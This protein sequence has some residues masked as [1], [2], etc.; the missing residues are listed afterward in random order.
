[1]IQLYYLK[2]HINPEE[3]FTLYFYL[4]YTGKKQNEIKVENII[5]EFDMDAPSEFRSFKENFW[6]YIAD[7]KER[8]STEAFEQKY[9]CFEWMKENGI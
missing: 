4:L 2:Q 9:M 8:L 5:E 1:M 6:K 7:D 3:A